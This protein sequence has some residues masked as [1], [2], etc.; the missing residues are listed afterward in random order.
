MAETMTIDGLDPAKAGMAKIGE[1]VVL[2]PKES[3]KYD[4]CDEYSDLFG[5]IIRQ[6]QANLIL[7]FKSVAGIDSKALELLVETE[8]ALRQQG[9]LL[10]L[11]NLNAVCKDILM[12]TRL[13]N[14]FHVY[15]DVAEA[16]RSRS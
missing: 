1:N 6:G 8:D 4:N 7:D 16:A 15:R 13:I 12:V 11:A 3:L 2:S 5:Q 10:K 9:K 14:Q